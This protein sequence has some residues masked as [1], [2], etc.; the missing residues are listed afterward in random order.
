MQQEKAKAK[1]KWKANDI[2]FH[3]AVYGLE[4]KKF[5]ALKIWEKYIVLF[6]KG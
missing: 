2:Y 6:S 3:R 5:L 4:L 1:I